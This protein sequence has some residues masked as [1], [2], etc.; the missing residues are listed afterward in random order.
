MDGKPALIISPVCTTLMA[1]LSGGYKFKKLQISGDE[2]FHEKPDK[3]FESHVCESLHYGLMG[4]GEGDK[5]LYGSNSKKTQF[6]CRTAMG[7]T[8]TVI[9]NSEA[10]MP[11]MFRR[12]NPWVKKSI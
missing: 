4:A 5:A 6:T 7:N 3:T 12:N 1:G 9:S 8:K 2:R 11:S 10:A